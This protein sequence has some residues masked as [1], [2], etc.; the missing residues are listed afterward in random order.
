LV[1]LPDLSIETAY[2][3]GKLVEYLNRLVDIGVAGFRIDAAKHMWPKD[4]ENV[5][6]SVKNLREE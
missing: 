4:I 6:N 2:V 1:S 3:R 5:L